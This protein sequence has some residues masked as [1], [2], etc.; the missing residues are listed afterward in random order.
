MPPVEAGILAAAPTATAAAVWFAAVVCWC[1]LFCRVPVWLWGLMG[2]KGIGVCARQAAVAGNAGTPSQPTAAAGGSQQ[3]GSSSPRLQQQEAQQQQ[4]RRP[5]MW[6]STAIALAPAGACWAV[7]CA[8]HLVATRAAPFRLSDTSRSAGTCRQQHALQHC[9]HASSR[10]WQQQQQQGALWSGHITQGPRSRQHATAVAGL[11]RQLYTAVLACAH[12][13]CMQAAHSL[14]GGVPRCAHGICLSRIGPLAVTLL[15]CCSAYNRQRCV[16]SYT[17]SSAIVTLCVYDKAQ[18]CLLGA[19]QQNSAAGSAVG[20]QQHG[21][22]S[23][24][25]SAAVV[26]AAGVQQ[27]RGVCGLVGLECVRGVC[28]LLCCMA[29]RA[30][31]RRVSVSFIWVCFSLCG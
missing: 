8:L 9:R 14:W 5:E 25:A 6:A 7:A 26:L 2:W 24:T 30:E 13:A 19:P 3:R 20:R 31:R 27:H 4:Q 21:S 16:L 18:R 17:L 29:V 22:S 1:C 10:A 15:V 11:C 23:S 28:V 12:A